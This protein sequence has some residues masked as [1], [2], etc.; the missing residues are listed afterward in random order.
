MAQGNLTATMTIKERRKQ[1]K[2]QGSST[3]MSAPTT[4]PR[5]THS[6]DADSTSLGPAPRGRTSSHEYVN[7]YDKSYGCGSDDMIG[8]DIARHAGGWWEDQQWYFF[9]AYVIAV[10]LVGLVVM[11]VVSLADS[12][13]GGTVTN[14]IHFFVTLYYLH[15]SKGGYDDEHGELSHMTVWE[16]IAATPRAANLRMALRV[17]PTAL[18]YLACLEAGWN[19]GWKGAWLVCAVNAVVWYLSLLG[20]MPFMNGIRLFGINADPLVGAENN[21]DK[22]Q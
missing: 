2:K 17:V 21:D 8:F 9:S 5:M 16:Q 15:W 20:K 19:V 7:N 18:C 11:M 4:P 1:H 10:V 22:E 12:K 14:I 13:L 3:S 6:D